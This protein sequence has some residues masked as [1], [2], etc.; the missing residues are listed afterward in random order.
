MA[1]PFFKALLS[2][3]LPPDSETVDGLSVV[4][5]PESSELL[6]C[7]VSTIYPVPTVMPNFYEKVLYLHSTCQR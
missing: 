6:N 4:Q 7:L 2:L 5:S 1:S 3:P